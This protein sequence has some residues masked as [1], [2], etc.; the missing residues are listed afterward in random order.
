MENSQTGGH[1]SL[2][3]LKINTRFMLTTYINIED[4]LINGQMG[5][6]KHIEIKKIK[7]E[8]CIWNQMISVPEIQNGWK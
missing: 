6:V 2:L 8:L 1:P 7:S 4:R 3:E 5:N